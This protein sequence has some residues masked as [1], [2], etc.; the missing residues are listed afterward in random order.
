MFSNK[1]VEQ[2]EQTH[3]TNSFVAH[4]SQYEYKLDLFFITH[5]KNQHYE[6]RMLCIDICSKYCAIVLIKGKTES[7]LAL[8]FV[9]CMNK[10]GGPPQVIMTYGEGAIKN[11]GLFFK[12][13]SRNT[14]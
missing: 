10:M 1:H 2:Q 5:L 7:D 12:S 13:I 9:E 14:I 11:S 6:E 4:G 3:R 8:G